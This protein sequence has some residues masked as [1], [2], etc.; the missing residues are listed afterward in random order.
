MLDAYQLSKEESEIREA[1]KLNQP[2]VIQRLYIL[3]ETIEEEYLEKDTKTE[4]DS[5]QSWGSFLLHRTPLP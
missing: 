3:K 4:T 2:V 5:D 1:K